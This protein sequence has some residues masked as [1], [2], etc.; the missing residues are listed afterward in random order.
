[1]RKLFAPGAIVAILALVAMTGVASA[2]DGAKTASA[3]TKSACGTK[4]ASAEKAGTCGTKAASAEK[5]GTCGTKAASASY[6]GTCGTKSAAAKAAC[7]A[8]C[9]ASAKTASNDFFLSNYFALRTAV[10]GHCGATCSSAASAFHSGIVSLIESGEASEHEA[11]LTKLAGY[12]ADWPSDKA[13]QRARFAQI[14]EWCAGYCEMYPAKTAG[15]KVVTCPDS[16][17]RWVEMESEPVM[18]TSLNG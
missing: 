5:A 6:A 14:A 2:C 11:A 1:M 13:A 7:A 8:S 10:D 3:E 16:G 18:E 12:L 15:A 9:G 4:V 17:K